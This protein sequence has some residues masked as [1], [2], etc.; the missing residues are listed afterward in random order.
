MILSARYPDFQQLIEL[1][2]VPQPLNF[3]Q[4]KSHSKE[5]EGEEESEACVLY[6]V[7]IIPKIA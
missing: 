4:R 3:Q 7:R 5:R 2:E 1:D 6:K